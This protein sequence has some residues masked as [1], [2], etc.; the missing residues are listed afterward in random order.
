MARPLRIELEGGYHHVVSHGN[1]RLWLFRNDIQRKHF[2]NL[3]GIS[4]SKYKT[5]VHAFVLMTNHI[6]LLVETPLPNLNQFMRKLLSD[7]AL[8]YNK[9]YRR[10]G[11][12]FKSRYGSFLIQW[13]N[14]YFTVL[15]YIYNNPV[16]VR[17]VDRPDQYRWSS[18]YY[19]NHKKLADKE[20]G[21]YRVSELLE[22]V[23]GRDSLVELHSGDDP[24]LPIIYGKFI[25][26]RKWADGMI[27]ENYARLMDEISREKQMRRG[28]I[29]PQG[30][31]GIVAEVLGV[32]KEELI[33]SAN[34]EAKKLCLYILKK[35][36][37]LDA[38]SIGELFGMSKWAVLKTVERIEHRKK[39]QKDLRIEN[40]I[41]S[42]MSNVQT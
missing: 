37:P 32:T 16:R 13:D 8:Y 17:V 42:K 23:G 31:V 40:L 30:V 1:G 5:I 14:Y 9:W 28:V 33:S 38:R 6:H 26:E 3:L 27:N 19:L 22:L 4:A 18:L 20:V 10:R 39:S 12:V 35:N 7:Y 21:W 29:D 24:E 11:S 15:R 34:K 41:K 25:G 2:L 36:T